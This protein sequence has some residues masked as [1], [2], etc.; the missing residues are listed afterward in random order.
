[1]FFETGQ[2]T[3]ADNC[4]GADDSNGEFLIIRAAH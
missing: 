4:A 2:M 1:M 3:I